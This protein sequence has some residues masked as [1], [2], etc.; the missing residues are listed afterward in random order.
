[1]ARS[2]RDLPDPD[3]PSIAKHSPFATL[4]DSGG[5]GSIFKA[6]MRSTLQQAFQP[7]SVRYKEGI[8]E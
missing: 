1:M 4:N 8:E 5:K 3:G 2:N 6:S 7:Q